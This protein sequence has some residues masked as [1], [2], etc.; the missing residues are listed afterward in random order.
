MYLLM[1]SGSPNCTLFHGLATHLPS[2]C[3]MVTPMR[4]E[5]QPSLTPG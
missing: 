2:V 1:G 4:Q 3:R 5:G